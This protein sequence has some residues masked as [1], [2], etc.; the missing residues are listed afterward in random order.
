[1]PALFLAELG[2]RQSPLTC[3]IGFATASPTTLATR[4][5]IRPYV[6]GQETCRVLRRRRFS[7]AAG[8]VVRRMA[9]TPLELTHLLGSFSISIAVGST[10]KR[11][12][13]GLSLMRIFPAHLFTNS[14]AFDALSRQ[15]A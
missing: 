11:L 5:F 6:A 13:P 14:N 10:G 2:Y 12:Q 3:T 15:F 1:M 9:D 7:A 4:L 8:P